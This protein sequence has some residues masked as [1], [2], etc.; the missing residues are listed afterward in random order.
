MEAILLV[1]WKIAVVGNV[2]GN[3]VGSVVGNDPPIKASTFAKKST[4]IKILNLIFAEFS[5]N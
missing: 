3:V 2:V 1:W 5:T 4:K